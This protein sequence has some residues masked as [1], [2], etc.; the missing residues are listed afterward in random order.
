MK[1]LIFR[2]SPA[3]APLHR[4]A[5]RC[6]GSPPAYAASL[7]LV[8]CAA[9]WRTNLVTPTMLLLI[10]RQAAP[11]GVAVIGQSLTI[12]CRSLDLSIGGIAAAST[13]LLTCGVMHMSAPL[14][15]VLCVLFGAAIGALNG[16]LIARVRASAVLVTLAVSMVLSGTVIALS[17]M[18]APG[19]APMLLTDF[20]AAR[21][22]RVPLAPLV[23]LALLVPTALF[24]RRSAFGAALDAIGA[25]P[26]AAELSGMPYLQVPF[27]AHVVSGATAACGGLLL[28]SFVGVGSVT[29][30]A[31]LTLNSL[32][33]TVLGGVSFGSGRGAMAGPAVAAFMMVFLFNL[34]TSF[35][36]GEAGHLMM[37]GAIIGAAALAYSLRGTAAAHT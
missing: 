12:R 31:D 30:G 20:A 19:D 23:W 29:L 22:G 10:L 25:N 6:V 4:A 28:L 32:A 14:A 8:A 37:E 27:I 18:H 5:A 7:L 36:L 15:L 1:T 13:Y 2:L 33:A 3:M 16:L 26:R 24:L 35:G 9:I 11:L 17:R 34:L 21:L